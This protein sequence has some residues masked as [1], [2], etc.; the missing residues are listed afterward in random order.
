VF[1]ISNVEQW[2]RYKP[3]LARNLAWLPHDQRSLILRTLARRELRWPT[4]DRWH[5][6][7][8]AIDD[9]VRRLGGPS[10]LVRVHDL[11]NDMKRADWAGAIPGMS[12]IGHPRPRPRQVPGRWTP[13]VRGPDAQA[14]QPAARP[15]RISWAG[16]QAPF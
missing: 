15:L 14:V 5:F 10:P 9:F 12:V 11:M 6:S 16:V 1:Y 8:Q 7:A 2:F 3:Q 13:P 4:G